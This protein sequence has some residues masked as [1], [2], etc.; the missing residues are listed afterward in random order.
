MP[1]AKLKAKL[2][3]LA[4]VGSRLKI[5]DG[6]QMGYGFGQQH[7]RACERALGR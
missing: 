6:P 3:R 4:T 2:V 7:V 1:Q 5:G